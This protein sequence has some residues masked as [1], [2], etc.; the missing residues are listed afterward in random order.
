MT[1]HE[2]IVRY[3][4]RKVVGLH[5]VAQSQSGKWVSKVAA[6]GGGRAYKSQ[7]PSG[8]YLAIGV[9]VLIGLLSITL[10]RS[11][12]RSGST[13]TSTTGVAPVVGTTTYAALAFDVCGTLMTSIPPSP[14]TPV[15]PIAAQADG[16]VR[17]APTKA[18]DAGTNATVALFTKSYSSVEVTSTS[19]KLP[20]LG[21]FK[22][23]TY[24]NGEACPK[25]TP[26][27]GKKGKVS[28]RYWKNFATSKFTS[29]TDSTAI[30]F[31]GNSLVTVSFVPE[32]AKVLKPSKATIA[33]MQG[34]QPPA[35]T[36]T[37]TIAT[38]PTTP[39]TALRPTTPTAVTTTTTKK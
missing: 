6:T 13:S 25:G 22:A 38:G 12:Y 5:A 4:V 24:T 3:Q 29:S 33:A 26:D 2:V 19:L 14:A 35:P 11:Q 10:A 20:D 27:A 23:A 34:A 39:T 37:T 28:I 16:V 18:A 8:F 15:V 9:I 36:T 1:A 17:L 30:H 21:F 32:G 7:K 31:T